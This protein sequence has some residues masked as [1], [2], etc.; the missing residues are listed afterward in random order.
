MV[1]LGEALPLECQRVRE[2]KEIYLALP[3]GVGRFAALLMEKALQ[4]ADK[5]MIEG[6]TVAMLRIYQE[7]QGF[8]K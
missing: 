6:D 1:T 4:Q 8:T 7:L 5:A 2:L 3:Q